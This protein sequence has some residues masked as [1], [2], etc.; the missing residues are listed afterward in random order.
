MKK[1][2]P[3]FGRRKNSLFRYE[4]TDEMFRDGNV[5]KRTVIRFRLSKNMLTSVLIGFA[6][7]YLVVSPDARAIAGEIANVVVQFGRDWLLRGS[8]D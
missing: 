6:G 2:I 5:E 3:P 1:P 8:V 7:L 4:K